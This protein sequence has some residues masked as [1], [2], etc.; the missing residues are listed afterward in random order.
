MKKDIDKLLSQSI[1]T[2]YFLLVIVVIIK[3]LG[4]NYFEIIQNNKALIMINDFINLLK[5][6][7]IWYYLTLYIN[8]YFILSITTNKNNSN[9]KIYCIFVTL[10]SIIF[11]FLKEN[12]NIP[13]LFV[14][15]DILYMLIFSI[16]YLKI[17]ERKIQKHNVI[18]Y[19]ISVA[20]MNISQLFSIFIRNVPITNQNNFITYF[21]LNLDY[22]LILIIIHKLYFMKGGKSLWAEVVYF[23]RR[24]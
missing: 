17:K 2:Y 4:G 16:I 18:N 19:I 21:I 15:I 12:I 23:G 8:V 6:K 22:L 5:I 10:F 24:N 20:I 14:I 7:Y 3:L 1:Q 9:I 13:I 11:Q